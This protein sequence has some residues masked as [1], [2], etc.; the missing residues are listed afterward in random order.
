ML[1]LELVLYNRPC[2]QPFERV[3]K[4]EASVNGVLV[5]ETLGDHA[6]QSPFQLLDLAPELIKVIIKFL[7]VDI[8]YII[9]HRLESLHSLL[10][11]R[12][13]QLH[14]LRKGLSLCSSQVDLAQFVKLNDCLCQVVYVLASLQKRVQSH[15]QSVRCQL[16]FLVSL[17]FVVEI[18]FFKFRTNVDCCL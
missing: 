5:V 9:F 4:L 11:L 15:K 7:H 14:S 17:L 6:G 12:E 10:K 18:S 2:E 16:P 1:L 3:Q 8:H 13:Y